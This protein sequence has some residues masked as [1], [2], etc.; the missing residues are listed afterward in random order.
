[1]RTTL[2][3]DD[4]VADAV[5]QELRRR[6]KSSYKEIVNDLIRAGLHSHREMKRAPKFKVRAR[7]LGLR[8]GL[9]YDDVGGLLEKVE[10]ASHR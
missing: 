3:L 5:D 6:P 1:M 4:D 10:G 7:A 8:R 2:T 9:N